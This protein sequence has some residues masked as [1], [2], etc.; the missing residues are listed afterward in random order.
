MD[1][2]QAAETCRYYAGWVDKLESESMK[3]S[4]GMAYTQHEPIGVGAAIVPWNVPL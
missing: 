2:P 3:I 4:Q 1:I